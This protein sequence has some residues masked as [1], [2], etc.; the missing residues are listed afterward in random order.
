MYPTVHL[1]KEKEAYIIFFI[2][3]WVTGSYDAE[4]EGK[5]LQYTVYLCLVSIKQ[6]VMML[7]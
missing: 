2:L 4:F 1:S 7:N 5:P 3:K 6:V